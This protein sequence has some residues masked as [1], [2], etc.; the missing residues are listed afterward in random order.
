MYFG[1]IPLNNINLSSQQPAENG[2]EKKSYQEITKSLI[3]KN[4]VFIHVSQLFT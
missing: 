3:I 2:E 1:L 4:L